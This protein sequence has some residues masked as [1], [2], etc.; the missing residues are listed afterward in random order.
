M[1]DINLQA[2]PAKLDRRLTGASN[3]D[4][5]LQEVIDHLFRD[6][7]EVWYREISDDNSFPLEIRKM[8]SIVVSKFA[9][10]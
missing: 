5:Q 1:D 6:Y 7:I 8:F 4:E 9:A 3:I 2:K 10:R